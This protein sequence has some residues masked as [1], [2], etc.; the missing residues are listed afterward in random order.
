MI[1]GMLWL[2]GQA[3]AL[4]RRPGALPPVGAG[5]WAGLAWTMLGVVAV[6]VTAW[7][8]WWLMAQARAARGHDPRRLF[9]GLC[10]AHGLGW[11]DRRLLR[12]LARDRD[13]ADPSRLFV[14]PGHFDP[15][16]SPASGVPAGRLADLRLQLFGA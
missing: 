6:A 16:V 11:S 14:E 3:A 15:A 5:A 8:G 10:K 1:A 13:L 7:L 12:R 4:P 2:L 9:A